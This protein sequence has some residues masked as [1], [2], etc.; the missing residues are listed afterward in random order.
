MFKFYLILCLTFWIGMLI[1]MVMLQMGFAKLF[2]IGTLWCIFG[3]GINSKKVKEWLKKYESRG[4]KG[5]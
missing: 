1:C 5:E 3:M 2:A 4:G